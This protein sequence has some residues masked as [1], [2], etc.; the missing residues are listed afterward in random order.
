MEN[1]KNI[2]KK[3]ARTKRA[4]HRTSELTAAT[5]ISGIT[6]PSSALNERD[7]PT[8]RM[9]ENDY[10]RDKVDKLR[11][12]NEILLEWN[13]KAERNYIL[14]PGEKLDIRQMYE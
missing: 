11:K 9:F 14:N 8:E 4:P 10:L 1:V 6:F 5:N 3:S 13:R 2:T 7:Q 12:E